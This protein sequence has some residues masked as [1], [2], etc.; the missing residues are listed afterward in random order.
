MSD[1]EALPNLLKQ[2]RR[3]I[4]EISGDGAYDTRLCYEAIRIKRAAPLILG[5]LLIELELGNK[6]PLV[7][8]LSLHNWQILRVSICWIY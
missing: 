7:P 6:A 4:A 2:T 1:G 3:R 8:Q 5:V